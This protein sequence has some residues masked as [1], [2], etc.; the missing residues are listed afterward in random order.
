MRTITE[1]LMRA[2]ARAGCS[3]SAAAM[4]VIS[5]PVSEKYTVSAPAG[6]ASHPR[7]ARPPQALRLEKVGPSGERKPQ[8]Y[9]VA[10]A[11]NTRIAATLIEA[12]QNSNSPY[13]RAD[14]RLT[15][16]MIP[17]SSSPSS[18]GGQPSQSCRMLAPAIAST[19]TT[20]I[21]KYQ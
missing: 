14:I 4:V 1:L 11:M 3:D 13:E 2:T 6:T 5:A 16:V 7:G 15:A 19:G 20:I 18:H 17:M 21:Q 12:N 10:S 9:A 8:A